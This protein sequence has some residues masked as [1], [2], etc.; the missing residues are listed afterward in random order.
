MTSSA[1][2]LSAPQLQFVLCLYSSPLTVLLCNFYPSGFASFNQIKQLPTGFNTSP[3]M[4]SL[5]DLPV[6]VV[7][8]NLLP[9]IPVSDV[10]N[11]TSTNRFFAILGADDTFW[12]RK[13][14]DDFNFTGAGTARTSGWKVIYKGLSK[15]LIY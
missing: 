7:L 3:K 2:S 4:P 15:P 10:L 9:A 14:Q 5:S 12:K 1:N 11:L 8:D 13:L 6:D